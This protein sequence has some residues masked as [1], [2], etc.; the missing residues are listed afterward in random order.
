MCFL[1][2]RNQH[3]IQIRHKNWSV[4]CEVC[5]SST[6]FHCV[7]FKSTFCHS[8]LH[9]LVSPTFFSEQLCVY[10]YHRAFETSLCTLATVLTSICCGVH[11]NH[12]ASWR[13]DFDFP[14]FLFLVSVLRVLFVCECVMYCCH[15]VSTLLRLNI[16]I[17]YHISSYI[18]SYHHIISYQEEDTAHSDF[19]NSDVQKVL[20]NKMKLV[21]AC[22]DTL[23]HRVQHLL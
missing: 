10:A 16:C 4:N 1:G 22:T 9:S 15:R 3:G 19:P 13:N 5:S 14:I 8:T 21:Q 18:I 6:V 20:A 17:S 7:Y 12:C 2:Y 23:G 11:Q